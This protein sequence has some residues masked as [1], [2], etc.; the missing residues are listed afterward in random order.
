MTAQLDTAWYQP[1]CCPSQIFLSSPASRGQTAD[2]PNT[3]YRSEPVADTRARGCSGSLAF[4]GSP[5]PISRRTPRQLPVEVTAVEDG[6]SCECGAPRRRQ[7][8]RSR[9]GQVRNS[10]RIALPPAHRRLLAAATTLQASASVLRPPG[11]TLHSSAPRSLRLARL[12]SWDEAGAALESRIAFLWST[13][14]GS[15]LMARGSRLTA[16]G[17]RITDHSSRS[18]FPV[19]RFTPHGSRFTANAARLTTHASR[20]PPHA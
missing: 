13:V 10:R 6:I 11:K 17:S 5:P 12:A 19:S 3:Q 14:H 4:M 16:H 2:K 7:T 20:L 8:R 9:S 18:R 1:R 15:T